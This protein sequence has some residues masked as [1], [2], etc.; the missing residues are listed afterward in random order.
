MAGHIFL[1]SFRRAILEYP[2]ILA[3]TLLPIWVITQQVMR[4]AEFPVSWLSATTERER[5]QTVHRMEGQSRGIGYGNK[6]M[7]TCT[8]PPKG[9]QAAWGFSVFTQSTAW[10]KNCR[11]NPYECSQQST[12]E[13][14]SLGFTIDSSLCS[15]LCFPLLAGWWTMSLSLRDIQVSF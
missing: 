11:Q 4:F 5:E 15:S 6:Q 9:G 8:P 12:E 14:S 3:Q 10:Q 13:D 2:T 1:V 7:L